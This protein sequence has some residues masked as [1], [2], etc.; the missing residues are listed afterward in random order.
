M[1]WELSHWVWLKGKAGWLLCVLRKAA[2]YVHEALLWDKRKAEIFFWLLCRTCMR[3]CGRGTLGKSSSAGV[4]TAGP[5]LLQ[6]AELCVLTW[7]SHSLGNAALLAPIQLPRK[8]SSS[9]LL[10]MKGAWFGVTEHSISLAPCSW[11]ILLLL[12][13]ALV[14]LFLLYVVQCN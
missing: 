4:C 13:D 11:A 9:A 2:I 12:P 7:L 14:L 8:R 3:E 1:I 6:E 5:G 10:I